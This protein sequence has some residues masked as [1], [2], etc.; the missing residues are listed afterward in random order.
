[1]TKVE[2]MDQRESGKPL[3]LLLS[4]LKCQHTPKVPSQIPVC[5]EIIW[6]CQTLPNFITFIC[7]NL[8]WLEAQV[9]K[10]VG[11]YRYFY[12]MM[13]YHWD[14]QTAESFIA[15]TFGKYES[16]LK[17]KL[18]AGLWTRCFLFFHLLALISCIFQAVMVFQ[19][20]ETMPQFFMVMKGVDSRQVE[21]FKSLIVV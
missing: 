1:M 15:A 7:T 17:N 21:H 12:D 5:F 4:S 14:F 8:D 13:H 10:H 20:F 19:K 18:S 16:F 9:N 2:A 11:I 6:A 3:C